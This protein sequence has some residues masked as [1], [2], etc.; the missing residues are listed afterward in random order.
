[1]SRHLGNLQRLHLK[2]QSAFGD[3][4]ALVLQLKKEIEALESI[5]SKRP[6]RFFTH[7]V[8]VSR[9]AALDSLSL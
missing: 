7:S 9:H 1:M 5:E 2:L 6:R 8:R 3:N 4:A